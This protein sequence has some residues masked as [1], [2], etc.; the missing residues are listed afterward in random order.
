MSTTDKAAATRAIDEIE[1]M[2]RAA[3]AKA[4]KAA[5]EQSHGTDIRSEFEQLAGGVA[6]LIRDF[7]TNGIRHVI[8]SD[9][10]EW[11]PHIAAVHDRQDVA[12][13]AA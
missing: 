7:I 12:R 10:D 9:D 11:P 6:D 4:E 1:P 13:K 2:L 3:V 5:R 8:A